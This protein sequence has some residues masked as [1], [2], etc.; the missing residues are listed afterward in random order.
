MSRI[1]KHGIQMFLPLLQKSREIY[2]KHYTWR[3][4]ASLFLLQKS[5]KLLGLHHEETRYI[6][7]THMYTS[8]TLQRKGNFTVLGDESV[9]KI[10]AERALELEFGSPKPTWMLGKYDSSPVIPTSSKGQRNTEEEE[11]KRMLRSWTRKSDS[12]SCI[13]NKTGQPYPWTIWILGLKSD[14]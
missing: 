5:W 14:T 13:L 1:H 7:S 3:H 10:L 11:V 9:L 8:T 4:T 2:T 12:L 6:N